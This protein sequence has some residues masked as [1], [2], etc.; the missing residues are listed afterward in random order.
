M[1]KHLLIGLL[2]VL[3][4]GILEA[5]QDPQFTQNM[6]NRLFPNPGVAGSNGSICGTL[7]GRQQ[8]LGFEGKPETYLFSVHAPVKLLRGGVGLSVSSDALGS[9]STFGLKFAY[10]YRQQLGIGV[11]GVGIGL[12]MVNKSIK[13]NWISVDPFQNDDAIPDNGASDSSFDLDFGAYYKANN[14]Y[15]GLST[16]HITEAEMNDIAQGNAA[17]GYKVAR[18]YYIMAG[19]NDEGKLLGPDFELIPS[20]LIKTDASSLQFDL[21]LNVL[22]NNLIWGGVTYR[23]QDAV[24]PMVGVIKDGLGP[25]TLKV[26]F[27]YDITTS[28]IRQY[29]SGTIEVMLNYC[30]KIPVRDKVNKHK[31]VRFL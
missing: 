27:S 20:T 15:V 25:G 28:L 11:L 23:Y 22:Y 7:L 9:E 6:H 29:S 26:G 1:K 12:G 16:T 17:N 31:T 24:A 10:A 8:W 19:Y 30:F 3:S 5:Q 14:F 18:H 21:N 13:D 4:T 2:V